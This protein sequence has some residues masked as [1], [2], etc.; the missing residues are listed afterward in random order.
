MSGCVRVAVP[1]TVVFLLQQVALRAQDSAALR[2]S[3]YAEVYYAYDLS[4]PS[5]GLRPDFL[6][7]HKRHNEVN[8][9]LGV[10]RAEYAHEGVR[11]TLGLMAGTY[12]QYNLAGEP[13]AL[14]SIHEARVGLRLS[15]NRELWVDAGILPS[16]IGFEGTSGLECMTLTRS[17]V[18]ENS[19]YYE[20]GA[21][22]SYKP[23]KRLLI[24]GLI[25]NGWQRIQREP[26][27]QRP[28]FGTQL[29]YDNLE[30][31][32]LNWSTFIGSMGPDS[33]GEWR[34]YNNFYAQVEG[35]NSGMILGMDL[36]FQ[37]AR[38]GG[39]RSDDVEGWLTMVGIY[40]ARLVRQWWMVG[41]VEYFLDDRAVVTS[42]LAALGASLGLDFRMSNRSSWRIEGKLFGSSDAQFRDVNGAPSQ[43]NMAFTTAICLEF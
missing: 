15:R 41:R 21:M 19:P 33:L 24:A 5:S 32:V 22:L 2:L 43:T 25:L 20:A 42:G 18:A 9:N 28:A 6:F 11:A 27:N 37:Q 23:N 13:S 34:S 35:E 31:T 1:L 26:G 14:R 12:A 40:R 17:I 7:N 10:L 8:L 29:K 39:D 38:N 4:R 36:G 30:G 16:H 3:G